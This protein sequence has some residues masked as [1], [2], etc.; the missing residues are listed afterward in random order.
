MCL[1]VIVCIMAP[2]PQAPPVP[3][4]KLVGVARLI[5]LDTV[6]EPPYLSIAEHVF[7]YPDA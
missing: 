1:N 4:D 2:P 5:G 3:V 6:H 7:T